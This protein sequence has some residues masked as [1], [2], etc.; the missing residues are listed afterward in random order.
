MRECKVLY[1][2]T[3][4]P[5]INSERK[6]KPNQ[7]PTLRFTAPYYYTSYYYTTTT[8]PQILVLS[9]SLL[10]DRET[11][12]LT[13]RVYNPALS[14]VLLHYDIRTVYMEVVIC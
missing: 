14:S 2:P 11:S 8:L 12:T 13:R 7:H 4:Q 10:Y 3:N 1:S 6:K 9:H 5:N